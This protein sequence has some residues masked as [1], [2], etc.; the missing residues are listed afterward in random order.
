MA[1]NSLYEFYILHFIKLIRFESNES[2]KSNAGIK[3]NAS[4]LIYT[5]CFIRYRVS[6]VIHFLAIYFQTS[7]MDQNKSESTQLEKCGDRGAKVFKQY[8]WCTAQCTLSSFLFHN[9]KKRTSVNI[10]ETKLST[11]KY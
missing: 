7:E 5:Q 9:F 2:D 4:I 6:I 1:G 8:N 3:P 10:P 11:V